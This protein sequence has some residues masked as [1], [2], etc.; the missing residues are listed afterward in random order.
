MVDLSE[1][2]YLALAAPPVVS[3]PRATLG[4]IGAAN[5]EE[6]RSAYRTLAKKYHPDTGE[7]PDV[8][9]FKRI[10]AAWEAIQEESNA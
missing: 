10:T 2:T 9:E 8:D 5:L 6:C 1:R 4:V 7:S 3:S